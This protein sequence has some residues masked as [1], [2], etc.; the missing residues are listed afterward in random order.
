MKLF[1]L[2]SFLVFFTSCQ[3]EQ[4]CKN[5]TYLIRP[6]TEEVVIKLDYNQS[7]DDLTKQ[8]QDY[9]EEDVCDKELVFGLDIGNQVIKAIFYV[10][11]YTIVNCGR[12]R[13][14]IYIRMNERGQ[15]LFA[16]ESC[17]NIDSI[18]TWTSRLLL[19][20]HSY[21]K[22]GFKFIWSEDVPNEKLDKVFQQVTAGYLKA[23][24]YL[25]HNS[26]QKDFC[27]LDT[28]QLKI[29][30]K[31][32]PF[33]MR[34]DFSPSPPPPPPPTLEQIQALETSKNEQD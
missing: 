22:Q 11:C 14:E 21:N 34:F 27:S 18:P 15:V 1:L 2:L 26:L 31:K 16:G 17:P 10:D 25:A 23:Y 3:E 28:L 24:Q 29:L 9:F 8:V 33:V 12:G 6:S 19:S 13:N 30:E 32:L 4:E 20:K 7:R 5:E